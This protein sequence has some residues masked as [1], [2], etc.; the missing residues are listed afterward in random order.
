[1][2]AE[3]AR[4]LADPGPW[5]FRVLEGGLAADALF[6]E[7]RRRRRLRWLVGIL[8]VVVVLAVAAA[9]GTAYGSS[10]GAAPRRHA[11]AGAASGG[12][13]VYAV[14]ATS[15]EPT[16]VPGD[17]VEVTEDTG[18]L[19][20]GALVD[21]TLPTRFQTPGNDTMIKR[22]VG[23]PGETISSSGGTVLINGRPLSEPYLESG[24]A[25]GPAIA[26]QVIPSGEYFVLGDNRS[27]SLDSSFFGPI[28]STSIIGI[29]TRIVAPPSRAGAI[30]GASH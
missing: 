13:R 10:G 11:S 17:H 26:N 8:I 1:M 29:A 3:Q 21:F 22:V 27:D 23:L 18:V 28:P 9:I 16:L 15:M 25:A 2:M 5:A 14:K 6:K 24:A 19:E 20:R 12:V 30:P 4:T 7:A